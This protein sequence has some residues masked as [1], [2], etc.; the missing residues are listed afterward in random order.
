MIAMCNNHKH[1]KQRRQGQV[2]AHGEI[3]CTSEDCLKQLFGRA[4][5]GQYFHK[6]S[7]HE[8]VARHP[9]KNKNMIADGKCGWKEE[10]NSSD[11]L[12]KDENLDFHF[13]DCFWSRLNLILMIR[14]LVLSRSSGP[15]L[16]LWLPWSTLTVFVVRSCHD[17]CWKNAS[18]GE[19]EAAKNG[20]TTE[21]K[22]KTTRYGNG[23]TM[24]DG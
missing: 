8:A 24:S 16:F 21:K 9:K 1:G 13:V 12:L 22:H 3:K 10:N 17:L 2:H 20:S 5:D 14:I 11:S 6:N 15:N 19:T 7:D 23:T 18:D 4:Q